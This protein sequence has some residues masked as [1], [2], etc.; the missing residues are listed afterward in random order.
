MFFFFNLFFFFFVFLF[1]RLIAS[2]VISICMCVAAAQQWSV[3]DV[4]RATES[5]CRA[6]YILCS[7]FTATLNSEEQEVKTFETM[8]YFGID[9]TE[10]RSVRIVT[11][12]YFFNS[13]FALLL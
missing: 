13:I 1:P 7:T 8:I 3:V 10:V 6:G 4:I 12:N 9:R 5:P 2:F 11:G